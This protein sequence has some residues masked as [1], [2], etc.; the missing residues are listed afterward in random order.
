MTDS[1][2]RENLR[3]YNLSFNSVLQEIS[4]ILEVNNAGD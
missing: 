1:G 3:V 4:A 2:G